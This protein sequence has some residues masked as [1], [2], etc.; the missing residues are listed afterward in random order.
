MAGDRG[1]GRASA[2]VSTAL[3]G[4]CLASR[5]CRPQI[6]CS[7]ACAKPIPLLPGPQ[8]PPTA[9]TGRS[10]FPAAALAAPAAAMK[11]RNL[12]L[13]Y[14][15]DEEERKVRGPGARA[16]PVSAAKDRRCGAPRGLGPRLERG[17][18][19]GGPLLGRQAA[20][21]PGGRAL[22]CG[23]DR[24][25]L[26][27]AARLRRPPC[28]SPPFTPPA[29]IR[30]RARPRPHTHPQEVFARRRQA[31]MRKAM[32]LAVLC[33]AQVRRSLPGARARAARTGL[34][35]C[36]THSCPRAA[37]PAALAPPQGTALKQPH[38]PPRCTPRLRWCCLTTRAS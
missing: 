31:L 37:A 5:P 27:C 13:A 34:R 11:R 29:L 6:N 33:N 9:T 4:S 32:E 24:V 30:P 12:A 16:E 17:D 19:L 8:R 35:L 26:R 3:T 15:Q 20:A 23:A 22:P 38:A 10:P 25:S 1:A 18:H 28:G 36:A 2:R 14:I 21:G 7:S